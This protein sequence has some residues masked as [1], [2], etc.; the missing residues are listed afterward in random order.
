[1]PPLLKGVGGVPPLLKG[2][3]GMPPPLLRVWGYVSV[4]RDCRAVLFPLL[5]LYRL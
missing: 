3:G 2:A 5:G 4:G 1:M